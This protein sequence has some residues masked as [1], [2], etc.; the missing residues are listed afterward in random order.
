MA[1]CRSIVRSPL[2]KIAS[3]CQQKITVATQGSRRRKASLLTVKDHYCTPSADAVLL[4][5]G[6]TRQF[7]DGGPPRA[8]IHSHQVRQGS[9]IDFLC[10][11]RSV[12]SLTR[13][14]N[15][16]QQDVH[17]QCYCL[18]GCVLLRT[19]TSTSDGGHEDHGRV[20]DPGDLLCVVRRPTGHLKV[21]DPLPLGRADQRVAQA[22]GQNDGCRLG[23]QRHL[24][25]DLSFLG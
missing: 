18:V 13:L 8:D 12:R 23:G 17:S 24:C 22:R 5:G 11:P 7:L 16:P 3:L 19:V 9:R 4:L 15:R 25:V 14:L 10:P 20:R 21:V 2:S 1:P 6:P